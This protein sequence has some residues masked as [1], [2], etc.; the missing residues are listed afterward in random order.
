LILV[1]GSGRIVGRS[2][3]LAGPDPAFVKL[4]KATLASSAL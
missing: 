4:V 1:D 3:E 2:S